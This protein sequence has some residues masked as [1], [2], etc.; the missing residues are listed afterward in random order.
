[1]ADELSQQ[2]FRLASHQHDV[3]LVQEGYMDLGLI[4]YYRGDPVTAGPHLEQSLRLCDTPQ[5]S[6]ALFPR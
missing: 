5:L 3:T 1:M 2:F 4:A 6:T